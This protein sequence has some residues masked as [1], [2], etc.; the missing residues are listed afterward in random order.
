[1]GN[2]LSQ[3]LASLKIQRDVDPDRKGPGRL[4]VAALLVGGAVAAAVVTY[5]RLK[6]EVF[7]TEIGMTEI[8]LISPA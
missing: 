4:I 3:D 1:M 5:P 6:G 7:K 8:A 2:P